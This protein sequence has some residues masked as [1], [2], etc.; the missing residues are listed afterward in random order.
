MPS[1]AAKPAKA[2]IG[3]LLE[4]LGGRFPFPGYVTP[5][6][7]IYAAVAGAV[8]A[9]LPAGATLLDFG[10]GA[11]DKTA[12]L[13]SLG[14]RCTAVDDLGDHWHRLPGV[15]DK[16]LDFAR[17][18]G[19]DFRLWDGSPARLPEGPFDMV[20]LMEV[21][22]HFHDSPRE[23]LNDLVLRLREGGLLLITVPNAGNL[24]KRLDL[25][26]GRSNMPG[27]AGFYWYPGRWRGHVREYVDSDLR[28]LSAFLGLETVELRGCDFMLRRLP[29]A[30]R[31]A[32]RAGTALLPRFKDSWML[33]ARKPAGWAPRRAL[34]EDE[35]DRVLGR[36][37][38]F[39]Y[40]SED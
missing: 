30:L 11:G 22:E 13:Q 8:A 33:L 38:S 18:E 6:K 24:R 21:L 36:A 7:G 1:T 5:D 15:R 29:R 32:Y 12:L 37:T 39:R 10:A 19:V 23:L 40:G 25:L 28:Q 2:D 9:H 17:G 14:Y 31:P 3:A 20:L 4:E 35:Q 26:R 16:I 27:Y 34:P